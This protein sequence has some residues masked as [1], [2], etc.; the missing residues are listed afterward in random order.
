MPSPWRLLIV[1]DSEADYLLLADNLRRQGFA[2]LTERVA[3]AAGLQAALDRQPWEAVLSDFNLPQFSALEALPLVK[4]T[5][6]DLPFLIVSGGIGEEAAVAAMRAGAHDF[7][8]KQHLARLGVSLAREIGDAEQRR[9]RRT[10]EAEQGRLTTDLDRAL[11]ESE[12]LNQIVTTAAGQDNLEQMLTTA[13]QHLRRVVA[14][15]GGSIALLEQNT[16]TIH[17]AYGPF[18]AQALGQ[19]LVR[20][21]GNRSWGVVETG[22]S[23]LSPDVLAQGYQPTTPIRAYLAVPLTWHGRTYG[24]LEIDSTEANAFTPAD[25][26][27]TQKVAARLSGPVELAYRV[28][29]ERSARQ[30]EQVASDRVHRLHRLGAALAGA[31][32]PEHVAEVAV[33]QGLEA[34]SA[35]A[36]IMWRVATDPPGLEV[37]RSVNYPAAVQQATARMSLDLDAPGPEVTRTRQAIWLES[38]AAQA[39]RY[40][41]RAHLARATGYEA[42]VYLPLAVTDSV[43]GVIA[44]SFAH[45][46]PFT[47]DEQAFLLALARQIAQAL[48]RAGMYAELEARVVER[49]AALHTS[50]AALQREITERRLAEAEL[51]H[52]RDVLRDLSAR[53]QAVREEE[54]TRIAYRIHDDLGQ[55]LA[56]LKMDLAWLTRQMTAL[57]P[58]P[59]VAEK[60]TAMGQLIDSMV[61]TVR[62]ITTDLRPGLL[63]D[64]GLPAALEWQLQEFQEQTGIQAEF[65]GASELP[66]DQERATALFR[67]VQEALNNVAWHAQADRVIVALEVQAGQVQLAVL[68]NGRGVSTGL[69]ASPKSLG[70][71]G[72]RERAR[73]LGGDLEIKN[74]AG[75]GTQ[76]LIHVPTQPT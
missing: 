27:L 42:L 16:L 76:V 37:V 74:R 49:T 70:L 52:S 67:I 12:L 13:L 38:A 56:G 53:L 65:R 36:G 28:A 75:G 2:A 29:A 10:A 8:S 33:A 5:D 64:F 4:A 11:A 73:R 23:F 50:N 18:A 26:A 68:D 39:A 45:V 62:V 22:Q 69:L 41:A 66:L 34:M 63:D 25:L 7:L 55:Q 46:H 54:R 43:L 44:F 30:A 15:T 17:A 21:P 19:R 14:F 61:G 72:M 9:A 35:A 20:R 40:P 60:L 71:L 24:L 6:P 58:A 47:P 59:A 31:L 48:E 51:E 3:T 1:E 32:L 57:T